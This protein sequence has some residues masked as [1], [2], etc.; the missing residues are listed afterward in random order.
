[1]GAYVTWRDLR[2]LCLATAGLL[3]AVGFAARDVG[4]A[5]QEPPE[6]RIVIEHHKYLPA[7]LTVPIGTTV[8]WVNRDD[9]PHTV[10]ASTGQFSSRG[11][12]TG[13]SFSRRFTAPGTFEYF[14]TLHP[15]MTATIT[16]K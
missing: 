1:M 10:T 4:A 7:R 16:V 9:D 15:Q 12:D 3:V 14:C 6:P 2:Y 11:I 5:Q 8:T 13:E